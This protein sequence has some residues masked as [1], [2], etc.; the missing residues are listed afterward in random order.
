[1]WLYKVIYIEKSREPAKQ[2]VF[3]KKANGSESSN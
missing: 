3:C 2:G 1:M